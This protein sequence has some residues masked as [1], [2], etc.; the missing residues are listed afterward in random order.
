MANKIKG[1]AIKIVDITDLYRDLK[2]VTLYQVNAVYLNGRE[3]SLDVKSQESS[4]VQ[5]RAKAF[6]RIYKG[7]V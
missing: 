2:V 6:T 5:R 1:I 3:L 4:D 7:N